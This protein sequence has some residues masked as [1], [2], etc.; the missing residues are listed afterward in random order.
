MD[1][2][3]LLYYQ[4]QNSLNL[5]L[6]HSNSLKVDNIKFFFSRYAD[7]ITNFWILTLKMEYY[8]SPLAMS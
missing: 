4:A 5:N 3:F 6:F 8:S 2:T 1:S 7:W